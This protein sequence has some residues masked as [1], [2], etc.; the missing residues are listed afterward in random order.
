VV[1]TDKYQFEEVSIGTSGWA[2]KFDANQ[3]LADQH[4]HTY[5]KGVRGPN[6]LNYGD[7]VGYLLG[8]VEDSITPASAWKTSEFPAVG[9][10]LVPGSAQGDPVLVQRV[11]FFQKEG[12]NWSTRGAVLYLGPPAGTLTTTKPDHPD[13]FVQPVGIVWSADTI[14]LMPSLL[15]T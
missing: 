3:A 14:F 5:L 12:W 15:M 2:A 11:G 1:Y 9:I 13:K 6:E 7:A 4:L 10:C 8:V